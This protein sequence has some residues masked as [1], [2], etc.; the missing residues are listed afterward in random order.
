MASQENP[1]PGPLRLEGFVPYRLSVLANRV[2]RGIARLY[3]ERFDVTI[4]EWRVLAVLGSFGPM[5]AIDVA[6]RTAM[7]KVQVSRAVARL[8]EAGR[9]DR[10]PDPEDGRR[11]VLAFTEAGRAVY[12]AIVPLALERERL[13]LDGL[14]AADLAALDRV[15]AW[16]TRR[17]AGLE[18]PAE[19]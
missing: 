17:A 14:S 7:D 12:R 11:A 1:D 19:Q 6:Q 13:L 15:M 16:L 8:V 5:T 9:L 10:T 4:P 3:A 18:A 2:S